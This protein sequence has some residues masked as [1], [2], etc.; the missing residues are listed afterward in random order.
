MQR[1]VLTTGGTGGHVFPALAVAEEL[2]RRH[3]DVDILFVGGRHGREREFAEAAGLRFLGLPVR[4]VMG[5]GVR[6][7]GALWGLF[8]GVLRAWWLMLRFKPQVVLG[9]GGYAGFAPVFAAALRGVPCA[10]HEQNSYPGSANRL[11]GRWAHR[12]FLSFPDT[13]GF[14]DAAKAEVTGNPV[15]AGLVA[16][17]GTRQRPT[18][19]VLCGRQHG[20]A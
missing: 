7:V 12:I 15:R 9:F 17:S 8:R 3:P 14:F 4:G 19:L 20:A 6:A 11:L 5:R 1:V 16:G 13:H 18:E 2:R 10:V